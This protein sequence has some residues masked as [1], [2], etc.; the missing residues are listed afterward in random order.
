MQS[1]SVFQC[2]SD[3]EAVLEQ[4]IQLDSG[5]GAAV[6]HRDDVNFVSYH[7]P[8]HHT[9]SCY[10]AG[11][12]GMTRVYQ[13]RPLRGGAPGRICVMPS[14]HHSDWD[15]KGHVRMF[16]LYFSET[17]LSQ[18]A[19]RI[20]D[21]GSQQL[22]LLDKT[23]V[24]DPWI[25]N[26]CRQAMLALNWQDNAERLALSS[27]SDMLMTYLL[28]H[29]SGAYPSLPTVK[30][31]LAPPVRNLIVDYIESHLDQPLS[32]QELAAVALLSEYHFAR[33]FK[34]SL[35]L[36]P[37]QY[38]NNRRLEKARQL[39]QHSDLALAEIALQCG[40]SSQSHF[41]NRFRSHYNCTPG[42]LRR[43]RTA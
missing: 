16:H 21:R 23:F 11:G 3:S 13:R 33:M 10:L 38:V 24:E 36:P 17:H 9:L 8:G 18:L 26:L 28:K 5:V 6:W 4:S 35:G 43:A 30:G 14:E 42:Q 40:F 37:H 29:Y 32:L 19:A 22:E 41:S 31:G 2:L 27:A 34:Q 7:K 25:H 39:L 15:V 20:Q 1:Q 12:L